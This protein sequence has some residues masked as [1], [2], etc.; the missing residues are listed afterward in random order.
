MNAQY[1]YIG[2]ELELFS[3]ATRWKSYFASQVSPYIG[4]RVLE[5]GAGIGG[6][7][8]LLCDG[9]QD[10][11]VCLEPDRQLVGQL[12]QQIRSGTLPSC[13]STF[14]GTTEHLGLEPQF[15]TIIYIDVL[16]HLA[17]DVGEVRRATDLLL[18]GGHL[19]AL[20]PA[21]QWLFSPFDASIGHQ[22]RYNEKTL[23]AIAPPSLERVKLI[24]LDSVGLLA[25]LA[26][27]LLLRQ[28]MPTLAQVKTWDRLLVRWSRLLDPATRYRV[29][30][31]ILAVW[32]K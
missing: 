25:S 1:K 16:E 23:A 13:C 7:T 28:T 29:G 21:H 17:D 18:P 32:R 12:A 5:A 19:I 15:D 8:A 30:K 11:W 31:S 24:Y 3:H 6:T 4:S 20:S 10:R 2:S 22:R 14:T 26:N 9:S 27:R